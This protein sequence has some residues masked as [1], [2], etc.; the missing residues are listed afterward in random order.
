MTSLP[1]NLSWLRIYIYVYM[2]ISIAK[3]ILPGIST[4][5]RMFSG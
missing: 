4:V 3:S 5:I 2:Y 1:F